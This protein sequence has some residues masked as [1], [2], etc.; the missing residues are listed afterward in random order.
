MSDLELNKQRLINLFTLKKSTAEAPLLLVAFGEATKTL[1]MYEV[2][3][4]EKILN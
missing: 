4:L 1:R 3:D 2:A